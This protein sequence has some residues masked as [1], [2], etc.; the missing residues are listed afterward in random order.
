MKVLVVGSG[1]REDALAWRLT[2]DGAVTDLATSPGNLG[3][4]RWGK[5][6]DGDSVAAA[7]FFR[8]DLVVI[9]P[10]AP[11]ADGLADRLRSEGF[12]V[13]G[14]GA[15]GARIESS[16]IFSKELM[17]SRSIPTARADRVGSLDEGLRALES[18][19]GGSVVV[20]VD[21]LAQGKGV[22]IAPSAGE[23]R[24]ALEEAFVAR[25]FGDAGAQVLLEQFLE[26]R[27]ATVLAITD[28]TRLF[29]LPTAEDH[30]QVFDGDK[31]SNTGG[32]GAISPT[33]VVT[34]LVLVRV[35]DRIL[36]PLLDALRERV[37]EGYR[38]VIY[39]GIMVDRDE[40]SVVEFNCRFGDP[41][42]Q[43]VLPRITGPFAEALLSAARGELDASSLGESPEFATGVVVASGGYPGAFA[44]GKVIDGALMRRWETDGALAFLSGVEKTDR[45]RT[46]GGRVA[47]IVGFGPT[48]E[49]SRARAYRAV[50]N[51]SFDGMHYRKDI[52]MRG[53]T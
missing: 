19:P 14:P 1:A 29:I 41:E 39:A 28:G 20:K 25:K 51:I 5:N 50:G 11:L 37:P 42:A 22:M 46:S 35:R 23:A 6:L 45:V 10:E 16:K 12:A 18:W 17:R 47:T 48:F 13:F 9:G 3:S 43:V 21:G 4:L 40:P 32:M 44:K 49:E 15:S 53:R 31:G 38:G 30:K 52:G 36:L 26:G 34:P 24:A 2:R 27:E 33:P 7:K 8:P